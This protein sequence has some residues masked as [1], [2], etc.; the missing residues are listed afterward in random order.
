LGVS[1]FPDKDERGPENTGGDFGGGAAAMACLKS[2]GHIAGAQ[3]FAVEELHQF[4]GALIVDVP[5]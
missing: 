1:E 5:E 3:V 4:G 2:G